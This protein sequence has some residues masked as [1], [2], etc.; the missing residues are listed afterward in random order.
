MRSSTMRFLRVPTLWIQPSLDQTEETMGLI[1][2]KDTRLVH[3]LAYS[4]RAITMGSTEEHLEHMLEK[5]IHKGGNTDM[6][7]PLL[8]W[9]TPSKITEALS[10]FDFQTTKTE[11]KIRKGKMG[12]VVNS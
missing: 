8:E 2:D 6:R 3:T 9:T 7:F 11:D 1:D 12:M 10:F 4:G 5:D